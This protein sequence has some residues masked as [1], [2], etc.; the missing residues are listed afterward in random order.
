MANNRP[1]SYL[2]TDPRWKSIRYSTAHENASIG[3]SGCGPTSAAMVI[4]TWVDS[5]V[6]PVTTC[7]WSQ[8][9]GYKATGAGTYHSYFVPQFKAYGLSCTKLNDNSIQY[10]SS[11]QAAPIHQKA[12]DAVKDGCCVIALMAPGNWTRGGHYILWYDVE[13]SST[14]GNVLINDPASTRAG[15]L[16]NTFALLKSQVRIYWVIE[17]PKEVISM[18][19]SEVQTLINN[20]VNNAVKNAKV[21]DKHIVEVA[22]KAMSEF[23]AEMRKAP[24]SSWAKDAWEKSQQVKSVQDGKTPIFDGSAPGGYITREQVAIVLDRL[25]LLD[26]K[27]KLSD[28]QAKEV[29]TRLGLFD[30][31]AE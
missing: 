14:S 6:T 22:T 30:E 18:R 21:D 26:G 11:S 5:K 15:R 8:S 17:P 3:G 10:M 29:L 19:N 2:Q 4:A 24:T 20:A 23:N 31:K 9:H 25:G 16:K 12:W 1:V 27:Y 28:E 13:G 7:A